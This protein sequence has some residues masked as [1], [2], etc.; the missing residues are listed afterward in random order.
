[1]RPL[2]AAGLEGLGAARREDAALGRRVQVRH[3]A[4][5][6]RQEAGLLQHARRIALQKRLGIGVLRP[7]E[8]LAHVA[9]LH[10]L[11]GIHHHDLV[12]QLG[13]QAQIVRDHHHRCL[14]LVLPW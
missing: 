8:Y 1:L 13:D 10:H 2:F 6:G 5:D 3:V 14:E 4:G 9:L 7:V 11:A 12:A